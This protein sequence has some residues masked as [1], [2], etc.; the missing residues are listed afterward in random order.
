MIEAGL[1]DYEV[2]GW[3]ALMAPPKLPDA[4]K[5]R[6]SKALSA[7]SKDP[8]FRKAMVDGGY[9][10]DEGDGKAVQGRI[11]REYAMWANVIKSANIQTN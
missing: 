1:K 4:V 8:V 7:V 5:A 3:Y 10:V 2:V 6:L 11:D 9:T